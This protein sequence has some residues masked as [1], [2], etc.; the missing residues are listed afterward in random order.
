MFFLTTVILAY[1]LLGACSLAAVIDE[2]VTAGKRTIECEF[3]DSSCATED[4]DN[5]AS[6]YATR[7]C[8]DQPEAELSQESRMMMHKYYR[9]GLDNVVFGRMILPDNRPNINFK[10]FKLSSVHDN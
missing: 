9:V 7:N 3:F 4:K 10:K 6:C 1:I 8:Y 2:T 5:A